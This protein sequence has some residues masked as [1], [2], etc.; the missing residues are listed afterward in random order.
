MFVAF[1]RRNTA[2]VLV[3]IL[4]WQLRHDASNQPAPQT[5]YDSSRATT[6]LQKLAPHR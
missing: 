3:Q 4:A 5:S 2:T 6:N 1:K